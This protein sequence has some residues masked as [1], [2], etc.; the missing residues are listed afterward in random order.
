ML[1]ISGN[2]CGPK[3]SVCLVQGMSKQAGMN[4]RQPTAQAWLQPVRG[5]FLCNCSPREGRAGSQGCA[6]WR[7]LCAQQGA[8]V[9]C[10]TALQALLALAT[11][12]FLSLAGFCY[13]CD[14][15]NSWHGPNWFEFMARA[16]SSWGRNR[17]AQM[18]EVVP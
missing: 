6:S 5:S 7:G 8:Q 4:R 13:L 10:V 11:R 17:K 18:E 1:P 16:V 14:S 15:T 9:T 3:E 12:D 2:S